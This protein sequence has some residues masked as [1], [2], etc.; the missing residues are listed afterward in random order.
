MSDPQDAEPEAA[1]PAPLTVLPPTLRMA[2]MPSPKKIVSFYDPDEF[3]EFVKEWVPALEPQYILV[4]R[5]GGSGDHGI[6]VAGCLSRERLEGEWHNYQCKRYAAAVTWS[7]AAQEMRKMFVAAAD[8]EFTVPTRYVFVAPVIS[9]SLPRQF[10]KPTECRAKFLQ[11]LSTTRDKLVVNLTG[12]QRRAVQELAAATDFAMFE[13]IDLDEMLALHKT[14]PHWLDRFPHAPFEGGPQTMLP[15]AQHREDE[16]R[17]V[18]HLVDVYREHFPG[19]I[20]SLEEVA[21]VGEADEHLKRQRVAFYA[22]EALRVFA[23]DATRPAYFDQVKQDVYDIVVETAA[24]AYP[25]GW[26]RHSAVMEAAGTVQLTQTALASFA[27]AR[28]RKG[29]CHHLANED[30]LTWC[31]EGER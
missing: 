17:Y 13:C 25:D 1:G 21:G 5:H 11:E 8:G 14:T 24:R 7:T 23:R 9:R 22:A 28:A 20:N 10:A 19:T 18:Q 12:E 16:A 3:E 15:P 30:R 26:E 2:S 31:R 27:G 4:E 6:D 29:V